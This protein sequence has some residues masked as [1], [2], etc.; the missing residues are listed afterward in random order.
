MAEVVLGWDG[1]IVSFGG[2]IKK[3]NTS[4]ELSILPLNSILLKNE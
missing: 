3:P 4:K 1:D 2:Y